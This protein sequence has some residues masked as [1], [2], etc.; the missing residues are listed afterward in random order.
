MR[1]KHAVKIEPTGGSEQ[2][3]FLLARHRQPFPR[4]LAGCFPHVVTKLLA[5]WQTPD[6][7]RAYFKILLAEQQGG[8]QGF[9]PDVYQEIFVLRKFYDSQY[10]TLNDRRDIRARI[11]I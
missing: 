4:R 1:V 10:P 2:L 7:A 8:C 3:R 11:S 6:K 5:L 9:P